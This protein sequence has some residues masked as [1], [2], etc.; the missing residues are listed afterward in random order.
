MIL[1]HEIS[2]DPTIRKE[3]RRFFKDY[4]VVSVKPTLKGMTK[5]DEM[6]PFNVRPQSSLSLSN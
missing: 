6:H 3:V 1:V 4:A 2:L 5:I